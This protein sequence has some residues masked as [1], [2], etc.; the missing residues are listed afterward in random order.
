MLTN[1]SVGQVPVWVTY[2]PADHFVY[3]LNAGSGSVSV[4]NGTTFVANVSVGGF[5]DGAAFDAADGA[6]YVANA[7]TNNVSILNGTTVVGTVGVGSGPDFVAYDAVDSEVYVVDDA[8]DNVSVLG[9]MSLATTV[10][11]GGSPDS[12]TVDTANGFVYVMNYVSDNVTVVHGSAVVG[13]PSVGAGPTG[14]IYD[15]S[16]G[17]VFVADYASNSTTVLNGTSAVVTILVGLGPQEAAFDPANGYVYVTDSESNAVSILGPTY[18]VT[19]D[20]TGLG[21]AVAWSVTLVATTMTTTNDSVA[22]T[23]LPGVYGYSVATPHGYRLVGASE[24]SPIL[25]VDANVVV[26]LTFAANTT[27]TATYEVTFTATG[28]M[29]MEPTWGVTLANSTQTTSAKSVVFVEPNGTYGYTIL[30]PSGY[31]V[32]SAVPAS[33]VTV[34]GGNVTV[35]VTFEKA[36][37]LSITFQEKGLSRG[38][39]WCVTVNTTVCSSSPTIVLA[40][41]TPGTYSYAVVPVSGYT[42]TPSSGNVTVTNHAVTV[43]VQ[44]QSTSHHSGGCGGGGMAPSARA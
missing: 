19:F 13:N 35:D 27:S 16:T 28:I 22:F 17:T 31:T 9:G 18:L 10:P 12:A 42:A 7:N 38:T 33:P 37:S 26:N 25:V 2:D 43:T 8:S 14:A 32:E 3:V 30:P 11:V 29:C 24:S 1:I 23:E 4:L 41:V 36:V 39:T 40:N 20:E 6:V 44:F 34:A 21:G 5:P 15:G